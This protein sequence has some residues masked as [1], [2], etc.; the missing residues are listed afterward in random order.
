MR[1][2]DWLLLQAPEDVECPPSAKSL[3]IRAP[4]RG[5]QL[6][7]K[8]ETTTVEALRSTLEMRERKIVERRTESLKQTLEQLEQQG[9]PESY[10]ESMRSQFENPENEVRAAVDDLMG[11]IQSGWSGNEFV[12]CSLS[13]TLPFPVAMTISGSRIVLPGNNVIAG[14]VA[15]DCGT[16]I[17]L[18]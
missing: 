18:G 11:S 14:M 13:A 3:T 9:T 17:A 6:S 7:I 16:A 2:N 5:I 4:Q 10:L 8:F 12:R 1:D 15:I